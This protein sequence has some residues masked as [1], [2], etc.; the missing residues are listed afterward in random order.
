MKFFFYLQV[1]AS[2]MQG[3]GVEITDSFTLQPL[4]D[5]YRAFNPVQGRGSRL[6]LFPASLATT[7]VNSTGAI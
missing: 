7:M 2:E 5:V 4:E 6:F 1:S 3:V